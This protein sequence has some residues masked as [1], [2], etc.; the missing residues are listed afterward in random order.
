MS[1]AEPNAT[2]ATSVEEE[3]RRALLEEIALLR[4]WYDE[5][6]RTRGMGADT[7]L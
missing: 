1:L 5:A 7:K 2:T 6:A 4:S 3:L